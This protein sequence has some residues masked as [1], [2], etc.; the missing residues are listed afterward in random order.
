MGITALADEEPSSEAV[1]RLS[2]LQL[3]LR[4]VERE[5]RQVEEQQD[6]KRQGV[7]SVEKQDIRRQMDEVMGQAS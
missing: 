1:L 6:F 4:R 2:F 5:L 7:L 3:E